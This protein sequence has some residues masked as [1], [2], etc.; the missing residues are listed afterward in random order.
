MDNITQLLYSEFNKITGYHFRN[1][2]FGFNVLAL[3]KILKADY[4]EEWKED[5]SLKD[6]LKTIHGD[7]AMRIVS[8]L[9]RRKA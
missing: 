2:G 3:E 8:E 4:P 1:R 5:K 6:N 9:L 7:I